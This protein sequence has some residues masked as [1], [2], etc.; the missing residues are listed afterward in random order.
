M[1]RCAVMYELGESYREVEI[2]HDLAEAVNEFYM[3]IG[4]EI[5]DIAERSDGSVEIEVDKVSTEW[6]REFA[7]RREL[8]IRKVVKTLYMKIGETEYA[9][10]IA[11]IE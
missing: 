11:E 3:K 10:A 2:Y 7:E 6:I 9:F 8:K 4:A 1:V 5:V